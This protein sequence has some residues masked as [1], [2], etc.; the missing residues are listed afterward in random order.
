M[1]YLEDNWIQAVWFDAFWTL[2][3]SR[4]TSVKYFYS[5][6][7][8][9]WWDASKI[10]FMTTNYSTNPELFYKETIDKSWIDFEQISNE[11]KDKLL[12]AFNEDFENYK[13]I[14][15][16]EKLIEQVKSQV[17]YTFLI[18]NLSSLYIPVIQK[19]WLENYFTFV[20]YSCELWIKKTPHNTKIFDFAW[21]YLNTHPD[22]KIII[23]RDKTIFTWDN[24][25][26]DIKSAKNAWFQAI[27]INNFKDIILNNK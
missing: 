25:R 9:Y 16:T 26:D 24:P 3:E 4:S 1:N 10:K 6:I 23:Q 18:S 22:T 21:V 19:L 11:E 8:K 7:K 15:W 12:L 13:L 20:L 2:I 5:L 17:D 27:E 14:D